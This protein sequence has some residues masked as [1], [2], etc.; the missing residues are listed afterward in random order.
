MARALAVASTH[1]AAERSKWPRARRPPAAPLLVA[2][3]LAAA[4][5]ARADDRLGLAWNAPDGC[6][7]EDSVRAE[8]ARLLGG[9]IP[10]GPPIAAEART[11]AAEGAYELTLRTN[12]GGERG[13][14]ALR[15]ERCEELASAAALILALMID[16]DAVARADPEPAPPSAARALAPPGADDPRHTSE[17]RRA[18]RD[19]EPFTEAGPPPPARGDAI[20][21]MVGAGIQLDVGTLPS[22]ATA[23]VVEG[24]FGVPLVDARVRAVF[25]FPQIAATTAL[26]GASAELW[27]FSAGVLACLRPIERARAVGI[28]ADVSAGGVLGSARGISDPRSGAGFWL[29]AGGGLALAW[30]PVRWLEIEGTAELLG[31]AAPTFDVVVAE[32]GTER[33]VVVFAPPPVAG[34]FTLAAHARF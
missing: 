7:A 31:Q 4:L 12:V 1:R 17:A 28:C 14:R 16:P 21:A 20:E 34:R 19:A 10:D 13:E 6:P 5:P 32:D 23:V 29:A 3:A 25:L 26:P 27:A 33:T 22:A 30:Q 18:R 24:G 8:V 2:L 15:A 11:I 9:A